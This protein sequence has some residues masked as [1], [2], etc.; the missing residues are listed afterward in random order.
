MK[1]TAICSIILSFF[2]VNLISSCDDS[3]HFHESHEP[4]LIILDS[5]SKLDSAQLPQGSIPN[6]WVKIELGKGYYVAFPQRPKIKTIPSKKRSIQV[7]SKNEFLLYSSQTDL[8]VEPV[9]QQYS[10]QKTI[11]YDA[12]LKDFLDDLKQERTKQE[13]KI[14]NRSD[15]LFL[16]IYP[17]MKASIEDKDFKLDMICIIIGRQLLTLAFVCWEKECTE[18]HGMRDVFF[19]SLG[20]ELYIE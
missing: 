17:A 8:V 20:K 2:L 18:L 16:N 13:P 15:F 10:K 6:N 3:T 11:F 5:S 19:N 7:F 14:L 1:K 4:N 12:I 9:F